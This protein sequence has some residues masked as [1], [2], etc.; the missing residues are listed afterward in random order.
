MHTDLYERL[1][2]AH[3]HLG[4]TDADPRLVLALQ[5]LAMCVAEL[6]RGIAALTE[7]VEALEEAV[8]PRDPQ[9]E[10]GLP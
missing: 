1:D 6:L 5:Q 2:R 7:R 10:I 4:A 9:M 8:L 3:S